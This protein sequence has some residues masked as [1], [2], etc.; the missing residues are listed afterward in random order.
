M[1]GSGIQVGMGRKEEIIH[2]TYDIH[3]QKFLTQGK[4]STAFSQ[5]VFKRIPVGLSR[6]VGKALYRH[7][8]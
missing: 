7:V 8:D 6:L 5:T 3:K 2:F 4:S 1:K